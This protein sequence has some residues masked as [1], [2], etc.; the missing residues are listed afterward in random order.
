MQLRRMLAQ[1]GMLVVGMA[2][3]GK[4]GVEIVL[5]ERPEIVLMDIRMPVMDGLEAAQRILETYPVC[6][7]M[8]TAYSTE[9]YQR[10]A[11]ETGA[12]GYILKPITSQTLLPEL[13]DAYARFTETHD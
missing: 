5:R 8:L 3:N 12:A 2:G 4:E 9:E 13:R 11:Q 10:R 6:I 1:A 7:L